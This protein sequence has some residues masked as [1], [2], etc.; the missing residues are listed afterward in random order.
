MVMDKKFDIVIGL[1]F[2]LER[3]VA[4]IMAKIDDLVQAVQD[5]STVE[6]SII[7]LLT[8]VKAQLDAA[9]ANTTIPDD[10][11]KKIDSVFATVEA[12]KAKVAAAILAKTPS[13]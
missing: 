8:S 10:V 5:E 7:A 6:D 4:I 12:N 2:H 3:K 1:L 13:A 11:Q 9:L